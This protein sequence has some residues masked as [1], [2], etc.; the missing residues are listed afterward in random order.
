MKK[1]LTLLSSLSLIGSAGTMA[2]SCGSKYDIKQDGNSV[3]VKFLTSLDGHAQLDSSDLL[4][5]LINSS[6][7]TKRESFLLEMLQLL[8]VSLLANSET[9][10]NKDEKDYNSNKDYNK[11]LKEALKYKWD[12]L[13]KSVDLQMQREKDTYRVKN[14]KSWE[15]EWRKMLVEK[16][17]VYQE[18][19][20]DMDQSFLEN[21]YKANILLSDST[22]SASKAILDVLLNTDSY[23]VN[24][25]SIQSVK[26]KLAN[27]LDVIGDDAKFEQVYNTDKKAISQILNAQTNDTSKWVD[28]NLNKPSDSSSSEVSL[29]AADA[30]AKIQNIKTTYI[31]NDV[32]EDILQWQTSSSDT[33]KGMLSKSQ[34]YF[35]NKFYETKAPL[36]ISEITIPFATNGKFD[37]GLTYDD[38]KGDNDLSAIDATK[39][40]ATLTS[41]GDTNLPTPSEP[42][43]S[44]DDS[45]LDLVQVDEAGQKDNNQ[46]WISALRDNTRV[47]SILS[48]ATVK[49]YDKLLTLSST[50][51]SNTLKTVVYDYVF[52]NDKVKP[53]TID[54]KLKVEDLTSNVDKDA[55]KK[56]F[57]TQII[58]PLS[59]KS[60]D[61]KD[62]YGVLKGYNDK[63][64]FMETDG[65]HI[66]SIDGY[67]KLKTYSESNESDLT[68]LQWFNNFHKLDDN[69]KVA[70]LSGVGVT[71]ETDYMK[72]LN[73]GIKSD[74]L[75][76]L[77]N[78]SLIGGIS[79]A[80]VSFD[81]VSD[82]KK[83]VSLT[84]STDSETYWMTSVFTYFKDITSIDTVDNFVKQLVVFGQDD[85]K[86]QHGDEVAKSLE[87]WTVDKITVA[88]T[89]LSIAPVIRF[90]DKYTNWKKEVAANTTSGYPKSMINNEKFSSDTL[91]ATVSAIWSIEKPVVSKSLAMHYISNQLGGNL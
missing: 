40:L 16:Y 6:G 12:T 77:V 74:Y 60:T 53:A 78:S 21:K 76:Y 29:S 83:W 61:G 70:Y 57:E 2:V 84:S 39:L 43:E 37:D 91:D 19:T 33:R 46:F 28:V 47:T 49:K 34:L 85:P 71:D 54:P 26:T 42:G 38:F 48:T 58:T 44:E 22:N 45:D 17:T 8:N 82:L 64:M 23:G 52:G 75:R 55:L 73:S 3:L 32:P 24:W 9:V 72:H 87:G 69:K 27:L 81:I 7:P 90:M 66:V 63:L 31:K 30:K 51:F 4:W 86:N 41:N 18:D 13:Q 14:G 50:D 79:D 20:K 62:F 15:K 1:L 5:E 59:R 25:V 11:G 35:L 88:E 80:P 10:M 56:N 68:Q 89:N 36:A 65:L 67:N